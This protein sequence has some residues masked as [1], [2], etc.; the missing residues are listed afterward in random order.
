MNEDK[1][2]QVAYFIPAA[3]RSVIPKVLRFLATGA[4][5]A[6]LAALGLWSQGGL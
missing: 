5:I 3:G 2:D 1:P 4:L 6:M